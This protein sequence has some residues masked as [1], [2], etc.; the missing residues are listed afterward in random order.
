MQSFFP[1]KKQ[2]KLIPLGRLL[3]SRKRSLLT[4]LADGVSSASE[5]TRYE[6]KTYFYGA[7]L[8]VLVRHFP[9]YDV[10][11]KLQYLFDLKNEYD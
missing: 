4:R 2:Q 10:R 7:N 9:H 1:N 6:R 11:N 8:V 3:Q 5:R